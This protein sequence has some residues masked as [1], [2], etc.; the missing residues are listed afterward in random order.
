MPSTALWARYDPRIRLLVDS[1]ELP[2]IRC[3]IDYELNAIPRAGVSLALGRDFA[4]SPSVVHEMVEYLNTRRRAEIFINPYALGVDDGSIRQPPDMGLP[5]EMIRIFSG[6]TS[7][8]SYDRSQGQAQFNLQLDHWLSDLTFGSVFS[9]SSHPASIGHYAFG[10]LAPTGSTGA[11]W[12]NLS[13]AAEFVKTRTVQ[14]D[15]WGQAIQPWLLHLC[16]QDAFEAWDPRH[17]TGGKEGNF[18]AALALGKFGGPCQP[19]LGL[20]LEVDEDI[21]RA[22]CGYIS[23][24][25]GYAGNLAHQSI[26]DVLVGHLASEFLFSIVPRVDDALVVPFVPGYRKPFTTITAGEETQIQ[27]TSALGRPLRGVGVTSLIQLATNAHLG[28]APSVIDTGIGGLYLAGGDG[29]IL[30]K[31]GPP[32]MG[33]LYSASMYSHES[34]GAAGGPIGTAVRPGAGKKNDAPALA[35]A[36]LRGKTRKFLDK[37]AQA[38]YAL[39]KLRGRQGIVSGPFRLDIAPGSIILVRVEGEQHIPTDQFRTPFYATVLRV[40]LMADAETPAIGTAFHVA[41]HRS[42][43]ENTK[44]E[45]SVAR[46][47]LYRETFSGCALVD[48]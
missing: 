7:Y 1:R 36:R 4:G 2:V 33:Q 6:F 29:L 23:Q 32:W 35:L 31:A 14:A 18:E 37:Y 20:D 9:R 39:E 21:A 13:L 22:I 19:T 28:T 11:H 30:I 3:S 8:A 25:T 5:A 45:T 47:P 42:E 43:Q 17:I 27:R 38:L 34:S 24:E 40:S 10:A 41:H 44:D 46:H 26:W 48:L 16:E 12:S 15:L